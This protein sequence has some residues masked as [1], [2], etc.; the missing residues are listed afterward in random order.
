MAGV[1]ARRREKWDAD[2]REEANNVTNAEVD[3]RIKIDDLARDTV[4]AIADGISYA[5]VIPAGVK[6]AVMQ[7]LRAKGK[8]HTAVAIY[9]FAIGLYF[10]LRDIIRQVDQIVIDVEYTGREAE[11]K[12]TLVAY[13]RRDVPH[14]DPAR[15]LFRHIGKR[16][17]AHHL[18]I[19][20]A[21]HRQIPNKRISEIEFL[22][23]IS[24]RK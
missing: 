4:L 7:H 5:I 1:L 17:S 10:L 14:F 16:S 20:I 13:L 19:E 12:N 11:I 9:A 22:G 8:S 21:R 18:A 15:I 23:V 24:K 3:Q 6:R 2:K